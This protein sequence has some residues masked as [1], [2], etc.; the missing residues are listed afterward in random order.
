MSELI[1]I[2]AEPHER[3][4]HHRTP[5][6]LPV[7]VHFGGRTM[8]ATAELTDVTPESCYLRGI[9]APTES[10]LAFGF[11]LRGTDVCLAAGRVVR[12]DRGGFAMFIQRS[13]PA[14]SRF[15][16][17]ICVTQAHAA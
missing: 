7:R 16:A 3:R 11:L 10:K 14:F 12:T 8:P 13:N 15:L 4:R 17:S 9:S 6:G 5:V 1:T 2:E